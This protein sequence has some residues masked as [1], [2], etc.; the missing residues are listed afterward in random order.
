MTAGRRVVRALRD[1]KL[2]VLPTDTVYGLVC[3]ASNR[4]RRRPTSIGSRAVPRSSRPRFWSPRVD[5]LPRY[6]PELAG[7]RAWRSH[8]RSC[9]ARTRSSSRTPPVASSGSPRA[10]RKRSASGFRHSRA[11]PPRFVDRC[12]ASQWRRARTCRAAPT[13]GRS[14]RFRPRSW[15]ASRPSSTAASCPGTP[16]TVID[17]TT[18]EPRILRAGGRRPGHGARAYRGRRKLTRGELGRPSFDRAPETRCSSI[19]D[20]MADAVHSFDRLR[21]GRACRD[22]SR[23]R[24]AARRRARA[25]AQPDRADRVGELHLAVDPRSGRLGADQQVRRGVSRQALLRRL[26]DRRPDRAARDRPREGALRGRARQCPASRRRAGEHG[27]LPRA[28][29]AGRHRCCHCAS[30]TAAISRTASRSTS[31]GASTRSSTTASR[32]RRAWSTTTR[33]W[34]WPRSTVPR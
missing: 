4:R 1:G 17:V 24:G 22:R 8:G 9:R 18:A 30:I 12:R 6:L 32:A 33:S 3:S 28:D 19:G 23:D 15:P 7:S 20:A 25:A 31:P 34:R 14:P 27:R 2:A 5:E 21:A 26:R 16:S 29:A 11:W 13:H 10:A